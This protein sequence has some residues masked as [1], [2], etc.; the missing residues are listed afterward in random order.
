MAFDADYFLK[1]TLGEDFLDLF[2]SEVYKP[3][4]RTTIDVFDIQHGLQ[5][6]PRVIM[7][8]LIKELVPMKIGET[9]EISIP[10]KEPVVLKVTKHERDSLSGE[11]IENNKKIAEFM[12]RSIPGCGIVLMSALELYDIENLTNE[13][14]PS[15]DISLKVQKIIDERLELHDLI[16]KVVDKK[17]SEKD[18]IH[19][20]LLMKL[21]EE[22]QK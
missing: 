11:I 6:V 17:I 18:A 13:V 16:N 10:H 21:N 4:T 14:K 22:L 15:E 8:L 19:Q 7:A 5:I 12:H 3:G 1:K 2:K 9:K 20:L